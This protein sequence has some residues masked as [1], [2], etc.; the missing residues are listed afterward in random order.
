M[1]KKRED[2]ATVEKEVDPSIVG[3]AN[4]GC[5]YHAEDGVPCEHDLKLAE[6]RRKKD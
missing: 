5:W 6:K 2:K 4:C 3:I 1:T